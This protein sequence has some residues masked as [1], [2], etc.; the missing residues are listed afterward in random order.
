MNR[1]RR[2]RERREPPDSGR[3]ATRVEQENLYGQV[4]DIL[5]PLRRIEIELHDQRARLRHLEAFLDRP[6]DSQ[7]KPRLVARAI[8]ELAGHADL[9]MHLSPA[10]T[11]DAIRLLDRR[12]DVQG[13]L[14]RGDI[15]ETESTA[16]IDG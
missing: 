7:R 15:V 1:E 2:V 14:E 6:I 8:Q 16:V 10:A 12:L 13:V 3:D 4:E 5:S 9:D 11:E